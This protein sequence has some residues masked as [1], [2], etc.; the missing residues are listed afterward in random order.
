MLDSGDEVP[1]VS[2]A[3]RE[4]SLHLLQDSGTRRATVARPDAMGSL[5]DM[6][7][8]RRCGRYPP[9]WG[10]RLSILYLTSAPALCG[11]FFLCRQGR[12]KAAVR[13]QPLQTADKPRFL[14]G[15]VF[16]PLL[17]FGYFWMP[18]LCGREGGLLVQSEGDF[19]DILCGGGH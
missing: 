6:A 9:P 5:P 1:T 8:G 16:C 14:A 4:S 17:G 13:R 15:F 19:L 2:V 11:R 18:E 3:P 7:S 10:H 12:E